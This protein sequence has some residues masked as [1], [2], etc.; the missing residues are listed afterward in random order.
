LGDLVDPGRADAVGG[1]IGRFAPRGPAAG[2]FLDAR[3]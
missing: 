1:L 2:A 3:V